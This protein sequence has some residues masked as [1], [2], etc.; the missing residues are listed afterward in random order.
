MRVGDH[1]LDIAF[2]ARQ[3]G[4]DVGVD[5]DDPG[6]HHVTRDV[7]HT[8]VRTDGDLGRHLGDLVPCDGDILP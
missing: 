5:V 6:R 8:H 2:G 3:K 1:A 4:V 7:D